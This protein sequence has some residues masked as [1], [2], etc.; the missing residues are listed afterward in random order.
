MV[1]NQ[2]ISYEVFNRNHN[3]IV[4]NV[5]FTSSLV[6]NSYFQTNKQVEVEE[7]DESSEEEEPESEEEVEEIIQVKVDQVRLKF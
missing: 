2:L 6:L 4:L 3:F 7:E 5:L 1:H